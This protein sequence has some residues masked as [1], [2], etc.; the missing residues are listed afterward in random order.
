[1]PTFQNIST[2]TR[3]AMDEFGR[4]Q[5]VEPN[6]TVRSY[7]MLHK[8]EPTNFS[9]T[10]DAPLLQ[11]S[12]RFESVALT[13]SVATEL[14]LTDAQ[15][16]DGKYAIVFAIGS[17]L[18]IDIQLNSVAGEVYRRLDVSGGHVYENITLRQQVDKIFLTPNINGSCYFY[19]LQE[20]Y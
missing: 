19:V 5:Q 6:Q 17:G 13:A 15:V 18:T 3:E 7:E 20:A 4:L 8:T 14:E 1:M 11:R 10:D 12:L 9:K 16:Q 2:E